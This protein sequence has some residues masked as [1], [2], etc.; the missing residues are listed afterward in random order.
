MSEKLLRELF[1]EFGVTQ[2]H[3]NG[4]F[5][6]DVKILIIDTGLK[7]PSQGRTMVAFGEDINTHGLA[8]SC[9][10]SPP[11][12]EYGLV[13]IAPLAQVE[14][15]DVRD[16]SSIPID[17]VLEALKRGID[18]NVDIISIS[19]GTDDNYAPLQAL[20]DEASAKGILVFAA[21]GNSGDRGYEFPAACF[22]AISVGS[23]NK[24]RQPSPFNTRNDAVVVFAPGERIMLPTGV[25]GE[26]E[27]YSGTSFAT[28]FAAGVA[29]LVLSKLRKEYAGKPIRLNRREMVDTLRNES[30]FKLNCDIHTYVMDKTCTN[31]SGLV[32]HERDQSTVS[33][34][35]TLGIGMFAIAAVVSMLFGLVWTGSGSK[36]INK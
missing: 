29:A 19:L 24:S 20:I 17:V 30:H 21:A 2:Y 3:S 6:Q 15:A 12:N 13:G 35:P 9:L 27:E 1:D 33:V 5:G 4:F 10:I 16:P 26:L 22:R 31:Y 23:I 18:E 8:V 25:Q 36:S 28:P 32:D 11:E 14:L 7:R 34:T